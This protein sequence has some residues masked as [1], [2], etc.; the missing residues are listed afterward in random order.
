VVDQV[1]CAD[2]SARPSKRV[3]FEANV[4]ERVVRCVTAPP[5]GWTFEQLVTTARR[6]DWPVLIA[7]D[8]PFGV[9]A[10]FL[11][12][13][14]HEL[15]LGSDATFLELIRRV[16]PSWFEPVKRARD[17]SVASP[18]FAVPKGRGA[19]TAFTTAANAAACDLL[20]AIDRP[21]GAKSVF[22]TAGIPG[23]VGSS[24]SD[25]WR[26]LAA[27]K[28]ADAPRVW[29]FDGQLEALLASSPVV[30]AETY[31]RALYA[32][33]LLDEPP[34]QRP[35]LSVAK[36]NASIRGAAVEDVVNRKWFRELRVHLEDAP[37]MEENEDAFDAGLS[38]LGL[39]RSML[40]NEPL[41]SG[42]DPVAEGGIL[43]TGAIQ[44][45]Q[46]ERR[47]SVTTR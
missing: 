14:R 31:P 20:R 33:A 13:A 39:L 21:T 43:G 32:T 24:A 4:S 3:V 17:W 16:P 41:S 26:S 5:D 22:I 37:L 28:P 29:P 38:A 6:R 47:Y 34:S 7:I 27:M 23:S 25:L 10:R 12:A 9:P 46:P 45:D 44:I 19:L 8:A 18:F 11:T 35:R 1:F 40:C 42:E 30:I 15:Q 2:W 36:T